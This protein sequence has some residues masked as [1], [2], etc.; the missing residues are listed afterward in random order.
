GR[1]LAAWRYVASF[2]RSGEL[3][4]GAHVRA[5]RSDS[6]HARLRRGIGPLYGLRVS[7]R[8]VDSG[9]VARYDTQDGPDESLRRRPGRAA[10]PRG[11]APSLGRNGGRVGWPGTFVGVVSPCRRLRLSQPDA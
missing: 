5:M 8:A 4:R 10:A 7:R 9:R 11:M 2:A 1:R 6:P 3:V